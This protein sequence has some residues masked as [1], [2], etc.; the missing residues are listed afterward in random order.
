MTEELDKIRNILNKKRIKFKEKNNEFRFRI[1][2]R[3]IKIEFKGKKIITSILGYNGLTP[4][5]H[6][7]NIKNERRGQICLDNNINLY[8]VYCFKANYLNIIKEIILEKNHIENSFNELE[9]QIEPSPFEKCL[10][11]KINDEEIL[12][13]S[14]FY[15]K[16]YKLDNIKIL[17]IEWK[18]FRFR[19]YEQL[20]RCLKK[21]KIDWNQDNLIIFKFNDLKKWIFIPKDSKMSNIIYF[22]ENVCDPQTLMYKT[23]AKV[24]ENNLIVIVGLG[25]LGSEI[26]ERFKLAG[27]IN[28]ILIDFDWL[29]PNNDYRWAY[30]TFLINP[31]KKFKVEI[32]KAYFNYLNIITFKK[33]VE[34]M[35]IKEIDLSK[36]KNEINKLIFIDATAKKSSEMISLKLWYELSKKYNFNQSTYKLTFLEDHGLALHTFSVNYYN[37]NF[38]EYFSYSNE[39]KSFSETWK[40]NK[41]LKFNKNY[42]FEQGCVGETQIYS[43]NSTKKLTIDSTHLLHQKNQKDYIKI[44]LLTKLIND[45]KE[46]WSEYYKKNKNNVT[47]EIDIK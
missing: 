16:N 10:Y 44:N 21:E 5:C 6:I 27:N 20:A 32:I 22:V 2:N 11:R 40:E 29:K 14:Q 47:N 46:E 17:E 12:F 43:Q 36:F 41:I 30:P 45:K 42:I 35:N 38:H 7:F 4:F 37:N 25:S 19:N 23:G 31:N 33:H 28:F 9:N 8:H 3:K 39:L 34:E 18:G 15:F 13:I 26:F 24:K 1:L